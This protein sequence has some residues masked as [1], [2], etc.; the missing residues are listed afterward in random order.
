[1]SARTTPHLPLEADDVLANPVVDI[2]GIPVQLTASDRRRADAVAAL[3]R[4]AE[5][6]SARSRCVLR[7]TADDPGCPSGPPRTIL[8]DVE[9]WLPEPDHLWLRSGEGLA[10]HVSRDEIVIGGDAPSLARAFRFIG[11]I[12]LTHLLAQKGKQVLHAG[13]VVVDGQ[14]ILIFGDTG[15]GKS[16]L[17]FS[18]L[19]LG[20]LALSDDMVAVH[21]HDGL[22]HAAGLPRP[23]SV[24]D[25]VFGEKGPE[26]RRVPEDPRHRT[27]LPAATLAR[28]VYPVGAIVVTS[29]GSPSRATLE[30]MRGHKALS[31]VLGA[32]SSL[33][34]PV[35]LPEVFA[36][37]GALA[38]RPAWSFAHG[39]DPTMRLDTAA[40]R[41]EQLGW[42]V[43]QGA[44]P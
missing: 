25:D 8:D 43:R 24:P 15:T 10:A 23:I 40:E 4:H 18:A 27:E 5:R 21:R 13:A 32:S 34:D 42:H 41:L 39:S 31:V 35:V 12:A 16:T 2:A 19:Q 36:V 22:V 7:F 14:A 3:F 20:W 28:G 1:V 38:R 44:Q 29:H 9:L 26:G 6:T 30:P 37:A 11:F 17:V 33:I